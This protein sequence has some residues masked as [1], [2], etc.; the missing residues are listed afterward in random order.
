MASM[1][2]NGRRS[3]PEL[4]GQDAQQAAAYVAAQGIRSISCVIVFF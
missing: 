4:V 2:S 3:F 1:M